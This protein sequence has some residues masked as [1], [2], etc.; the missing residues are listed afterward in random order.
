ML[1]ATGERPAS[2]LRTVGERPGGPFGGLPVSEL[3]ILIGGVALVVGLLEHR[4]AAILVGSVVCALAV[5][6]V[7]AREH[8][9]GFRSHAALLALFPS[10][11]VMFG[12]AAALGAPGDRVLLLIPA[13]LV[14][15]L[16]FWALRR[17]FQ[18]ARHARLAR[19][20]AQRGH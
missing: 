11:G 7:T 1:R 20:P 18:I 3:G 5:L 13:A 4:G 12:V 16:C 19:P 14:F 8:F 10:L 2:M 17:R 15:V 6:E 9:S